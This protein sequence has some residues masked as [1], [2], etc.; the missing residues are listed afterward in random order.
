LDDEGDRDTK[1][2]DND[3]GEDDDF[4]E[5]MGIVSNPATTL[6]HFAH[7]SIGDFFRRESKLHENAVGVNIHEAEASLLKACLKFWCDG[8]M[9]D[10]WTTNT[11]VTYAV[12]FWQ[13]HLEKI[14][15]SAID[16]ATKEE[17]G[18]M[19]VKSFR[20]NDLLMRWSGRSGLLRNQWLYTDTYTKVIVEKWFKD[21]DVTA[22][23]SE[24]D[25]TWV[26]SLES[27][28]E[29]VK[30]M[31]MI[32]AREWLQ[33]LLWNP[34]Q[35]FVNVWGLIEMVTRQSLKAR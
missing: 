19:L 16:V 34:N 13:Q 17:L 14:D 26:A 4:G 32:S 9:W 15:L 18:D 35:P 10:K 31:F 7:G 8:D 11:L 23:F 28:V 30:P 27:H 2:V 12:N 33:N 5:E 1:Y 21:K 3:P 25:K 24:D 29:L 22:K 20:E 6:V